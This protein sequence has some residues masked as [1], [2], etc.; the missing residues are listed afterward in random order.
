MNTEK[1][2]TIEW[3]QSA[4]DKVYAQIAKFGDFARC[5]G[6]NVLVDTEPCVRWSRFKVEGKTAMWRR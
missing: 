5:S 6:T 3:N 1:K 4:V 2:I